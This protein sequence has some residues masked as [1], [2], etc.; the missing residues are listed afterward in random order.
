MSPTGEKAGAAAMT[1]EAPSINPFS[2]MPT[3]SPTA[4]AD[5]FGAGTGME[6]ARPSDDLFALSGPNPFVGSVTQPQP[7]A[8]AVNPFSSP[9]GAGAPWPASGGFLH[10]FSSVMTIPASRSDYILLGRYPMQS[11]EVY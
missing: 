10:V 8:V 6:A 1:V 3:Q 5:L 2:G 9:T 7:A 4:S 11:A